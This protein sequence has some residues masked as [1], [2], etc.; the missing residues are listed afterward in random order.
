M[1]LLALATLSLSLL[2]APLAVAAGDAKHPE[3]Q[4]WH[5]DG[6]FGQFDRGQLQRGFLV[7]KTVCAACHGMNLLSYRNLGDE[8]GPEFPEDA[9]KAIAAGY[10]VPSLDEDGQPAERPATPADRFKGPHPNEIA[11]RAA[12]NGALPPDLSVIV[13]ARHGGADYIY[14][15]LTGYKDAPADMTMGAGMH[16]NPYFAGGQIAMAAPIASDDLVEYADGTKAT[17]DQMARDVTAFLTWA[18]EPRLEERKKLGVKVMAFTFVFALV[19]FMAYRRLWR[20]VPH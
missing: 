11:A 7:Y 18:S 5:W 1:R 8:G 12:N 16:Y 17:K 13:K 19:L 14:A 9:V 4:H 3:H 10:Q 2:A 6:V 20:D 15:L